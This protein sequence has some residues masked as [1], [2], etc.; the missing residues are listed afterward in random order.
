MNNFDLKT[1]PNLYL[2]MQPISLAFEA[3]LG[4]K[5]GLV[6]VSQNFRCRFK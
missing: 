4:S 1:E 3:E 2:R 6:T 5:R